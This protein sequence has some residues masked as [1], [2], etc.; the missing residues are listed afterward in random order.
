MFGAIKRRVQEANRQREVERQETVRTQQA[1][2]EQ[3]AEQTRRQLERREKVLAMLEE[4]KV[5][6]VRLDISVPFR[7]LKNERLVFGLNNVGYAEMRTKREIHGRS[8]GSSVRVMKGMSVRVG[9]S[10]GTPVESD[11]LTDR[12]PGT[13]AISTK[14]VFFHGERSFR[15]PLAKIV[16][17]Q[18]TGSGNVE[19]VRDRAS[20]Q[21]EYFGIGNQNADF[22][23]Q[24]IHLIPAVDFGRGEPDVQPIES[25]ALPY[26]D[27][28]ADDVLDHE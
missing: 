8:A 6:D 16:S 1:A 5:P 2:R 28:G 25:Y 14:H 13:F 27:I 17:A 3:A 11:V 26:G 9:A 20:A 4:G 10:K 19:V 21:P 23:V 7:L 18:H 22:V 24:L 15:I 12:G